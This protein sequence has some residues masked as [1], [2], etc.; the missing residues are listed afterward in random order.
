MVA[1]D[2][3]LDKE[4]PQYLESIASALACLDP[5]LADLHFALGTETG[6]ARIY[7]SL[8][9]NERLALK[10]IAFSAG[11]RGVDSMAIWHIVN[12]SE[13]PS[14]ADG[15]LSCE[16]LRALGL[17]YESVVIS[18]RIKY[19]IA[20][21]TCQAVMKLVSAEVAARLTPISANE[22]TEV[23]SYPYALILDIIHYLAYLAGNNVTL[24][25]SG[26]LWKKD[27]TRIERGFLVKEWFRHGAPYR[28]EFPGRTAFIT[29]FCE[30]AGLTFIDD[31]ILQVYPVAQT[32][33][34]QPFWK[35]ARAVG[36]FWRTWLFPR[37]G[38]VE[39]LA[40]LT[41]VLP[42]GV[43]FSADEIAEQIMP[44]VVGE[45]RPENPMVSF[46]GFFRTA[47]NLGVV[48]AGYRGR[49]AVYAV[50]KLGK[51]LLDDL[52]EEDAH[53]DLEIRLE[54]LIYPQPSFEILV[55]KETEPAVLW[56]LELF[57]DLQQID[58]FRTYRLTR[59]SVHRG[60]N[61]AG[62][63]DLIDLAVRCGPGLPSNVQFTI[64]DWTAGFGKAA[65]I[66]GML[67][68]CEEAELAQAIYYAPRFANSGIE[69][70]NETDLLIPP[71]CRALL[72]QTLA[73]LGVTLKQSAALTGNNQGGVSAGVA[74][75]DQG[76]D[77]GAGP[78]GTGAGPDAGAD[79]G[80]GAGAD[81]ADDNDAK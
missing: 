21:E 50:T 45:A 5:A 39:P 1:L 44:Y 6:V 25:Q 13:S 30:E 61:W 54:S 35:S 56:M 18:G 71:G 9:D 2:N 32:W 23:E 62:I 12:R 52:S 26:S 22:I 43:W 77:V 49:T 73:D 81:A 15:R 36:D 48:N 57:C 33:A 65:L 42:E 59:E 11:E 46:N 34:R 60:L 10:T 37:L 20:Q 51:W 28:P 79:A 58:G 80:A 47:L 3:L 29:A 74:G 24:T 76:A 70:L 38:R 4:E 41:A 72:D 64:K 66:P 31:S 75:V 16:R 63:Q 69:R 40:E 78:A 53:A 8:T 17:I 27:Q 19:L 7:Q 67:L 55:P 68:R 14:L